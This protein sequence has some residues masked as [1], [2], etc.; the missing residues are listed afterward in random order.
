[1]IL[2]ACLYGLITSTSTQVITE[3][4]TGTPWPYRIYLY[5]TGNLELLGTQTSGTVYNDGKWHNVVIVQDPSLS[6]GKSKGYV[7]GVLVTS[8]NSSG[9]VIGSNN[10]YIGGRN[11]T[12]YPY[13]G[14]LSNFQ[15]FDAALSAAEIE[16]LYNYGSPIRTLANTPKNSNLKV[17]YKLDASELYDNS[18]TEWKIENN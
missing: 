15:L 7:D 5:G 2:I 4:Q 8:S 16:T 1:M 11:G 13:K 10:F 17:W 12:G 9:G 14:K 18:T 3:K 6:T